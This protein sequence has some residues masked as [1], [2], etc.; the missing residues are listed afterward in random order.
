MSRERTSL[1]PI[2]RVELVVLAGGLG[3]RL[4]SVLPDQPKVLAD[5]AGRPFLDYQ[6]ERLA[7]AGVVDVVL[8]IGHLAEAVEHH[9]AGGTPAG[10]EVR[11]SREPVPLGT[12]GSV[13]LARQDARGTFVVLNGDSFFEV[14]L[15]RLLAK[16]RETGALATIA[17]TRIDDAGRY[18]SL[19][20]AE[21]GRVRRFAEKGTQGSG[22]INAGIY[23]LEPS[24]LDAIPLDRSTS[25]ERDVFPR[26]AAGGELVAMPSDGYFVDIGVPDDL[27]ELDAHP[28][29]LL[30]A[31]RSTGLPAVISTGGNA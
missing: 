7:R 19:D 28:E 12:A 5:V 3:T 1:A 14:P 30:E 23:V 17:A 24:V 31:V 6:L 29:R 15:D 16:H 9:L 11:I 22:L 18:G 21:D 20:L 26:L 25:L 2:A 13:T 8:A 4:R 27:A 10:L